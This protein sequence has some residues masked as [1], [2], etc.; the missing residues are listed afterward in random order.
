VGRAGHFGPSG[1]AGG[2]AR[3]AFLALV[4]GLVVVFFNRRRRK[5]QHS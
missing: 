4:V 3:L 2:L 1:F 5:T